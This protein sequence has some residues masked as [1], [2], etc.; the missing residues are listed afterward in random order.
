MPLP[1]SMGFDDSA[2]MYGLNGIVILPST[3]G[4]AALK[5]S[6]GP[7]KSMTTALSDM[8]N[9]TGISPSAYDRDAAGNELNN[10]RGTTAIRPSAADCLSISR[11]CMYSSWIFFGTTRYFC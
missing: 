6:H 5:I 9:A 7:A 10:D 2:T 3:F 1:A 8:T 4:M 11:R